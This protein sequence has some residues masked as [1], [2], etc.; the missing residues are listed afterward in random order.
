MTDLAFDCV[1]VRPERYAVAPTLVFRLRVTEAT[2][3]KLD[4]IIL[5][6]QIRIEPQRRRYGGAE[7]ERL[8]ELF[9]EHRRWGDTLRTLQFAVVS[10][11]VPAFSGS[12]EVDL[13]VPCTY[14]FEVATAKYF[15]A[16]EAGEVP[17]RLL[18]SGTAFVRAGTGFSAE[19]V[20]WHREASVGMPVVIW[21]ELMDLHFPQ[22]AWVRVRRD[23]LDAL[24][25]F[26]SHRA[27][28]TW[29]EAFAALLAEAETVR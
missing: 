24:Q 13:P 18:F 28:P 1:D 20:P 9:G 23:T 19:P 4:G 11:A 14:D 27:L 22:S 8:H 2:G 29:D 10:T 25:A 6:C 21:R 7:S 16:L 5:H 3:A 12:V 26:R 15:H 17:M